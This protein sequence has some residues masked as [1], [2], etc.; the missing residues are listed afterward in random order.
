M[1]NRE[2]IPR[3]KL[4]LSVLSLFGF[5]IFILIIWSVFAYFSPWKKLEQNYSE[6]N[7]ESRR[8]VLV[9]QSVILRLDSSRRPFSFN[10]TVD[11][12]ITPV[13]IYLHLGGPFGVFRENLFIPRAAIIECSTF[14][15]NGVNFTNVT[16][17]QPDALISISDPNKKIAA[18][19]P[20]AEI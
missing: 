16:I 9:G 5:G 1:S 14:D 12:A 4:A 10:N 11:I 7:A 3:S 13:G 18:L 15:W 8:D 2:N 19:C 17:R 20:G 6:I